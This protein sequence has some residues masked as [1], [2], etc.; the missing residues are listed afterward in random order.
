MNARET[1]A[2]SP[3]CASKTRRAVSKHKASNKPMI[4]QAGL[5]NVLPCWVGSRLARAG[6]TRPKMNTVCEHRTWLIT[7]S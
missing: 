2:A 1:Q 7:V 5:E 6:T 3:T 4:I